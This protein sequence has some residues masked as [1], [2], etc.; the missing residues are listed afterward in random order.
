MHIRCLSGAYQESVFDYQVPI[1][2]LSGAYQVYVWER[3]VVQMPLRSLLG[4][5]KP[6]EEI[7]NNTHTFKQT[8][9]FPQTAIAPC[10]FVEASYFE[11]EVIPTDAAAHVADFEVEVIPT[12]SVTHVGCHS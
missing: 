12:A 9:I 8:C 4:P 7:I 6:H 2:C 5:V 11:V 1:R 10:A 3:G